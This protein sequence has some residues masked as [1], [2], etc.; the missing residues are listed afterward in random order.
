M[1]RHTQ[2]LIFLFVLCLTAPAFPGAEGFGAY[3]AGGR[4][5][6]VIYVTNLNDHGPGSFR[7][8]C[9]A[10]RPRYILFKV[11]GIIEL[12][13]RIIISNPY[14]T[15]AG[16]TAPGD[17]ICLKN[18]ELEI[19]N[20]HDVILRY[21]RVRPGDISGE[22]QDAISVDES[23]NV[24]ID[25]CSA[26][27]G[28]DETLS[29]TGAGTD[30]VTIQ[31]CMIS[32]SLNNSVHHKGPHGYGSLIRTD[33]NITFHHNLYAH[34]VSRNPR[35]GTYGDFE[36][37]ELLDFRNNLIY[38]WG[39]RPGYTS[40][41]K[42]TLNYIENYLVPGPSTD[43]DAL[44]AFRIGGSQ[45]TMYYGENRMEGC[46]DHPNEKWDLVVFKPGI[47][48]GEIMVPRPFLVAPVQTDPV[49]AVKSRVLKHV[50]ATQP[51]RDPVD[52]RIVHEV[53]AK[54]GHIIDSQADVDGWPEYSSTKPPADLDGDGMPDTWERDHGLNPI[55]PSDGKTDR[56]MDGYPNIEEY[57]QHLIG[58]SG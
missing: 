36:R 54:S 52:E 25:H 41:D 6:E 30:S 39:Y 2:T 16:H 22:E 21:I 18:Y 9:N 27:W 1:T 24:I 43:K 58:E 53:I 34:H 46:D 28:T 26:S 23:R 38:N 55:N 42:A 35:P 51:K 31:W 40:T 44:Y 10:S 29:V 4:G 14:V 8:A 12:Q 7:A 3:T 17:G 57:L 11:S 19:E 47:T 20:T 49:A 56:D 33:G 13:S 5:G 50:G 37:G 45:T 15:I 32:E 48:P